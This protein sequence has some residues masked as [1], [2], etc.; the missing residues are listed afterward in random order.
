MRYAVNRPI[1][2]DPTEACTLQ[3]AIRAY[4]KTAAWINGDGDEMGQ[5]NPGMLAD[6]NLAD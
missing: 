1:G 6:F 5:L 3:E 4:T 2:F